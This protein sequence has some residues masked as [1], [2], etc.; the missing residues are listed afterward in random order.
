MNL[1]FGLRLLERRWWCFW[2]RAQPGVSCRRY[3]VRS[4]DPRSACNHREDRE[5]IGSLY[6]LVLGG[7]TRAEAGVQG[8]RRSPWDQLKLNRPL[9]D[10]QRNSSPELSIAGIM[11]AA[12][13]AD[14]HGGGGDHGG[15]SAILDS[16]RRRMLCVSYARPRSG[17]HCPPIALARAYVHPHRGC[18]FVCAVAHGG[19]ARDY[20]A[21][22]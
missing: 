22:Q 12:R 17:G 18:I 8:G 7:R 9:T 16:N 20:D 13:A 6:R 11:A 2:R 10:L 21:C 5:R 15:R 14:D 1:N 4:N 3:R 19:A